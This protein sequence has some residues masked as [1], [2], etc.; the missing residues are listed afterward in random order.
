MPAKPRNW[1]Q[2]K[3]IGSICCPPSWKS[4]L[5]VAKALKKWIIYYRIYQPDFYKAEIYKHLISVRHFGNSFCCTVTK[6]IRM[7]WYYSAEGVEE[8]DE[9]SSSPLELNEASL[10]TWSFHFTQ[11]LLYHTVRGGQLFFIMLM[12]A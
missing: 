6:T 9:T 12:T 2:R 4:L 1:V 3:Q 11:T 10:L 5:K 8:N 7:T